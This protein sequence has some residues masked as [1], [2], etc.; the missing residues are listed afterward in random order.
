[1]EEMGHHS[2]ANSEQQEDGFCLDLTFC[3]PLGRCLEKVLQDQQVKKNNRVTEVNY[4]QGTD[5]A[6]RTKQEEI[7]ALFG[8]SVFSPHPI[9]LVLADKRV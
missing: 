4:S 9:L 7:K 1:M 5:L 3:K 2:T 6:Q 8:I